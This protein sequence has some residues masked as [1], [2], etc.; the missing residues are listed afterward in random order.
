[1][2]QLLITTRQRTKV[3]NSCIASFM[4][5]EAREAAILQL[6]RVNMLRHDKDDKNMPSPEAKV[7]DGLNYLYVRM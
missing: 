1:M 3:L 2:F 4:S 6:N 5:D 7:M